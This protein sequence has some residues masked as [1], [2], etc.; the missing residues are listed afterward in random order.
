MTL[1]YN[2]AQHWLFK[3]ILNCIF[4][5]KILTQDKDVAVGNL[6]K[7]WQGFSYVTAF[8]GVFIQNLENIKYTEKIFI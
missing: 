1:F 4:Y 5:I 3:T 2:L 6:P 7:I 8:P